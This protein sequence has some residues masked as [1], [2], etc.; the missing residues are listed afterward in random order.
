VTK[1]MIILIIFQK[2]AVFNYIFIFLTLSFGSIES[3]TAE[4]G[5]IN[6]F[7]PGADPQSSSQKEAMVSCGSPSFTANSGGSVLLQPS[8]GEIVMNEIMADPNPVAG[9][10]DREYLEIFNTGKVPV[11]LKNWML[12]MGSK[13]KFFP[14]VVME[15]GEF[16]LVTST[17]GAKELQKFGKVAEIS[18]FSLTNSGVT[19]SLYDPSKMLTD[20]LAYLPSLHIKQFAGGGYSLERI[21]P[22]R[23]CGQSGNWSTTRSGTGGTPGAENSIHATN[24]DRTAP[25]ILTK[26]F[27]GNNKLE[28]RLSERIIQPVLQSDFLRNI[29]SGLVVDSIITDNSTFLLQIFFRPAS[30]LNGVGYSL[31]ICGLKDECGNIMS[32]QKLKFGY[33]QPVG[34]DLLISE[35]LFNPFPEGSDFVEIY[36]NSGHEVDLSGLFLATRD[37]SKSLKQISPLSV[38]QRYIADGAYVALT[39]SL[40]GVLR[41][42]RTRCEACLLEMDNFPSF[43]DLSGSVVL[44]DMNQ[45]VI[46]EMSYTDRMHHPLITEK[47]GIS[48]ERM[49]FEKPALHLD[50]WNSAAESVGFATP[51]YQNS[52]KQVKDTTTRAVII[53]PAVFSPNGDGLND[54]LNI[55]LNAQFSGWILNITILNNAGRTVRKLANNVTAGS[56]DSFFWDGLDADYRKVKPGIY[57]LY[58][59]LFHLSG[60]HRTMKMACVVTDRM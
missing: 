18:G 39:K 11:N 53:E 2:M 9:L 54:Q 7:D 58:V 27:T 50:N 8:T 33:Y 26:I 45:V 56:S 36:N 25:Q 49:S 51:G 30:V 31:D 28:I 57:V 40:E 59:S 44:L 55:F 48:L 32:D 3:K 38:S 34:S 1:L 42:Y 60:K 12:E 22:H 19:L 43:N 47:E 24:P 10:P 41:F 6:G 15:P 16:L 14:E 21:D 46:D 29:S 20:Q 35:V 23:L 52:A 37:D 13:Q 17:G 5:H 4:S